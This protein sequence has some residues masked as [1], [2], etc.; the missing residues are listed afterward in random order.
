[1]WPQAKE[2]GQPIE[3]GKGK[4]NRFSLGTSREKQPCQHH[5][6][7][8]VRPLDLQNCKIINLCCFKLL[9]LWGSVAAEMGN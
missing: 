3:D 8:S 1:M 4:G 5:D 6:L 9:I 7:R 2:C